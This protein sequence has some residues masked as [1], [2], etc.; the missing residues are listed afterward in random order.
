MAGTMRYYPYGRTR[1]TKGDMLTDK[2]FASQQRE[3]G[4]PQVGELIL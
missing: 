2:L 4:G 3:P 1:S